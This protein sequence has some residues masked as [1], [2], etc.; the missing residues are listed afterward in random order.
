MRQT[1]RLPGY[2]TIRLTDEITGARVSWICEQ[3]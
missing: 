2:Q 3:F 1:L